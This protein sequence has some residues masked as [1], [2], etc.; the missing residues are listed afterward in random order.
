MCHTFLVP[1]RR[2]ARVEAARMV[3]CSR[4]MSV[5]LVLDDCSCGQRNRA[6]DHFPKDGRMESPRMMRCR[7]RLASATIAGGALVEIIFPVCIGVGIVLA[8]VT[9]AVL[10]LV[11]KGFRLARAARE[12]QSAPVECS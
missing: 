1:D 2:R 12:T 11:D 4:R 8:V 3:R 7:E 10:V 5:R 6:A 9:D